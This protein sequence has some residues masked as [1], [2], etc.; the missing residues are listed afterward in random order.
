MCIPIY[1]IN[2][3]LIEAEEEFSVELT[4]INYPSGSNVE[5][6]EDE[7]NITIISEDGNSVEPYTLRITPANHGVVETNMCI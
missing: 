4:V 6:D 2:D 5:I 3:T 1:I 7:K